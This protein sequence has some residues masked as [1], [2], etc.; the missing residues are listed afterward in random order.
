MECAGFRVHRLTKVIR[1]NPGVNGIAVLLRSPLLFD[2]SKVHTMCIAAI[3]THVELNITTFT[4]KAALADLVEACSSDLVLPAVA[5]PTRDAVALS[6]RKAT[7][8][9]AIVASLDYLCRRNAVAFARCAQTMCK[10]QS[11]VDQRHQRLQIPTLVLSCWGVTICKQEVS[12][13][14][15]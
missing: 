8:S 3:Q 11:K 10:F 12:E 9:I 15:I 2:D 7:V 4:W 6:S 1:N 13:N 14:I 5:V